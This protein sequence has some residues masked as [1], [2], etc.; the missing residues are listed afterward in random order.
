M[1]ARN[2][3]ADPAEAAL[4]LFLRWFGAYYARSSSLSSF[5]SDEGVATAVTRIGRRW[6][7]AISVLNTLAPDATLAF[8]AGRAAIE[9]RLDSAGHSIALWLP[10]GAPLPAD[11]DG[12]AWLARAL[13]AAETLEDGRLELRRPVDIFLRRTSTTGSVVTILGGLSAHWA[14]FTG[15]VPGSFQLNSSRLLRLPASVADRDELAERIVLAAG[16]PGIDESETIPAVDAWTAAGLGEGGSCVFGTPAPDDDA[17]AASLRRNLR[18][19]IRRA[20]PALP[21]AVPTRA[22]VVVGAATYA[23]EE[24]LSWALRGMDPSL[25]AGFDLICV[26]AD[27]LV[28]PLLQPA[29]QT[30]PW[31]APPG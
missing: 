10:R 18:L 9:K 17:Q 8:E 14:R 16:Q 11:E 28:K 20:V 12:L 15:R 22:L 21:E 4:R 5:A 31:D 30:L 6:D 13:A 3:P 19:L 23:E 26:I 2:Y 25:Y 1:P 7:C 29:R 27:G 24:K